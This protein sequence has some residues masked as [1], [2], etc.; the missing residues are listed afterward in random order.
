M[1]R[2]EALKAV[3][4]M[5]GSAVTPS[6]ASFVLSGCKSVQGAPLQ[7][8][9]SD[10][11]ELVATIA[12]L[13]IPETDTPGARA[14]GVHQFIDALLTGGYRPEEREQ[15]MTGLAAFEDRAR[16]ENGSSF[17]ENTPEQQT[18]LLKTLE[19]E[20]KQTRQ[21]G[22]RGDDQPRPFFPMIKELTIAGYYTSEAG[23]TQEL[24]YVAVPGR[25]DGDVPYRK[26]TDRAFA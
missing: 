12:E 17:V 10:Q 7:T 25:Y 5:L 14:A 3:G 23:A 26:G 2:R 22:Q 18:A 6:V 15:F 21:S 11:G 1:N 16:K 8:L 4:L 13:I 24:R 19:A 20:A 9:T